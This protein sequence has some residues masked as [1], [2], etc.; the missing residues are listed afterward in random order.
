MKKKRSFLPS[1]LILI[2]AFLLAA[3]LLVVSM[4]K[5]LFDK[6]EDPYGGGTSSGE[7]SSFVPEPI[8]PSLPTYEFTT[9]EEDYL[10]D[11]LFIGDSRTVGISYYSGIENATFFCSTGLNIFSV[12]DNNMSVPVAGYGEININQLLAKKSFGK[13]YIMFGMNEVGFAS[14]DNIVSRYQTLIAKIRA[15]QPDAII[16]V[17]ACIHVTKAYSTGRP[18]HSNTKINNLNYTLMWLEDKNTVFYIDPNEVLDDEEGNLPANLSGDGYHPLAKAYTTIHEWLLT[19]AIIR[20]DLNE[21]SSM[22]E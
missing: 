9:A 1:F 3:I 6:N 20:E 16:Y 13:I 17:S 14:T 19:K 2:I 4:I 8:E 12:V 18:S 21:T 11:A 10:D 5:S 15:A 22:T 7:T